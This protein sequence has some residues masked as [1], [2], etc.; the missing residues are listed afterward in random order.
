M[1]MKHYVPNRCEPRNEVIVK[2]QR[3]S[4]A[5][6]GGEG[7]GGGSGRMGESRWM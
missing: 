4:R 1:F 6:E 3:K 2:T 5:G 7:G